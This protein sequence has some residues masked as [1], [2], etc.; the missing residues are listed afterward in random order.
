MPILKL[1]NTCTIL[2]WKEELDRYLT[3]QRADILEGKGEISRKTAENKIQD[4]LEK[5]LKKNT[6]TER[7]DRDFVEVLNQ[8]AKKIGVKK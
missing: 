7:I 6:L 1:E 2:N 3:Y 8:K 5:Y 4:E